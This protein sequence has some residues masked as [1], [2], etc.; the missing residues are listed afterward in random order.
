MITVKELIDILSQFNPKEKVYI[1][2]GGWEAPISYT[3]E[4]KRDGEICFIIR[5]DVKL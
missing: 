4:D 2:F 1:N 3:Y 5:S